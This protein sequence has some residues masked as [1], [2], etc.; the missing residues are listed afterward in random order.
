MRKNLVIGIAQLALQE[1]MPFLLSLAS[2]RFD[3]DVCLFV[4][5]PSR[6]KY[7][8][9][10]R[11]GATVVSY[12]R[13]LSDHILPEIILRPR[14][15][16]WFLD[17]T[18]PYFLDFVDSISKNKASKLRWAEVLLKSPK[19]RRYVMCQR[20]LT[21][22]P[23][24]YSNVMLTDVRDV[25]FQR[26]PFQFDFGDEVC[27]FLEDGRDT[28]GSSVTNR[29]WIRDLFGSAAL[30]S[31]ERARISCSGVTIGSYKRIM[32]Y[33]ETMVDYITRFVLPRQSRI[34]DGAD[35]GVHNYILHY[36]LVPYSR[37]F[38]NEDGPV[39]TLTGVPEVD[40]RFDKNGYVVNKTGEVVNV[41]HQYDRLPRVMRTLLNHLP[42]ADA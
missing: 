30:K 27:C 38:S 24:E 20:Y 32:K 28:I 2:I 41:V 3:G 36:G 31:M 35:Q 34:D 26:D 6:E 9:L 42:H 5:N 12:E 40:V 14:H 17:E 15:V 37:V 13:P 11:W 25:F 16:R 39:I 1:T 29:T 8:A 21:A 7:K 23:S 22:H 33:L 18:Y 10:R 4:N 19:Y